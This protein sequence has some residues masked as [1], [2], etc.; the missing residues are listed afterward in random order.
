MVIINTGQME[1][2]SKISSE[3]YCRKL[4]QYKTIQSKWNFAETVL[5][6]IKTDIKFNKNESKFI[7]LLAF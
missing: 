6:G 7:L 3:K 5:P 2:V 1:M 4:K